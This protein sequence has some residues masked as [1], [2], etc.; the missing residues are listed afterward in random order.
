M[1]FPYVEFSN[2][3]MYIKNVD[4]FDLAQTLDCGQAF[5][6]SPIDENTWH[7]VALGRYLKIGK[8][9]GDVILYDVDREEYEH[10]W[11]HYFDFDRNY[12]EI[13]DIISADKILKVAADENKGIRIL[14]QDSWEALCS[15]IISQ[16]NNIPRIKGI[17]ETEYRF[18]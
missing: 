13:I 2:G 7:G 8:L 14:N 12:A 11:K 17:I 1:Y 10:K 5:R 16:N 6:W 18:E 15:F 3:N 9:H 4:N